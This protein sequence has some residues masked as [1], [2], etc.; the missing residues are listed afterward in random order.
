MPELVQESE[1]G[2]AYRTED[3]LVAAI[4]RLVMDRAYRNRL[5]MSGCE[6]YRNQWTAEAH[7]RRYFAL[8]EEIAAAKTSVAASPLKE[9][10]PQGL[11]RLSG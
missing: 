9:M 3:E 6:T 5:G 4:D 10:G 2:L 11:C 8:I 1:G 7:L